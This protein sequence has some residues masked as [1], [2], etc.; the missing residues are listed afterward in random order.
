MRMFLIAERYNRNFAHF[1]YKDF[2]KSAFFLLKKAIIKNKVC[3][4]C[5][6]KRQKVESVCKD[7][8]SVC[9]KMAKS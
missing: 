3:K 8:E 7:V 1:F 9:K 4:V 6:K 5:V 2:Q